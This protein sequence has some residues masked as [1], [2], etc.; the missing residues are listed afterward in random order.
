MFRILFVIAAVVAAALALVIEQP[1]LFVAAGASLSVA[2]AM[3]IV[4]LVRRRQRRNRYRVR[5][6][7]LPDI[8]SDASEE[9][10]EE[11]KQEEDLAALGILDI[12]PKGSGNGSE[13]QEAGSL[14]E[15]V[16][17]NGSETSGTNGA[18]ETNGAGKTVPVQGTLDFS[19]QEQPQSVRISVSESTHKSLRGV[20][21][22]YLQAYRAITRA[23]TVCLLRQPKRASQYH[24]EAIVSL[25]GNA[26][27]NGLFVSK[28]PLLPWEHRQPGL[29]VLRASEDQLSGNVCGY[30]RQRVAVKEVVLL[31]VPVPSSL[32]QY[33]L[34]ADAMREH[35]LDSEEKQL[36]STHFAHLLGNILEMGICDELLQESKEDVR[37]RSEI[38]DEEI[39]KAR[40]EDTPL[41]LA[42]VYLNRAEEVADEGGK[43]VVMQAE[44]LLVQR[45]RETVQGARVERFGELMFGVFFK[46]EGVAVEQ[47]AIRFQQDMLSY[48]G[49]LEDGVSIGIALL[50]EGN[51]SAEALRREATEAL[52]EAFDTGM[53]TIVE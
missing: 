43:R 7:S 42:L 17:G 4:H 15:V 13:E 20:L 28:T 12:R 1:L 41:A 2:L 10:G 22:P 39:F 23:N 18:T 45:L 52:R 53:C 40:D 30:Y 31:P 24:I 46:E 50:H 16:S 11:D 51:A 14:T 27:G 49:L 6:E 36:L 48:S 25:N 5:P 35:I 19:I 34:L 37:P 33:V 44:S 3:V 9:E 32:A 29:H 47:W 21:L 8:T 26:R 38:I